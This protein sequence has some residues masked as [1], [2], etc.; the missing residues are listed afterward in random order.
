M[1]FVQFGG[2]R[3]TAREEHFPVSPL[4]I[5]NFFSGLEEL[6]EKSPEMDRHS[7]FRLRRKCQSHARS[8]DFKGSRPSGPAL[9]WKN[10][11]GWLRFANCELL[12]VL[13]SI[14]CLPVER[15]AHSL[16]SHPSQS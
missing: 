12:F 9:L 4:S 11:A 14:L 6:K 3:R 15:R 1:A 7:T 13:P 8:S 5:G 2:L 16:Y 10:A